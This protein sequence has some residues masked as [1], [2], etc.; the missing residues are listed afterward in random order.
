VWSGKAEHF[1]AV[2]LKE[3]DGLGHVG[4]GLIPLLSHLHNLPRCQAEDPFP[5][6]I[7]SAEQVGGAIAGDVSRHEGRAALA[8]ATA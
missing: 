2:V 3:I 7:C 6:E 8:A 4:V 1:A 5:G